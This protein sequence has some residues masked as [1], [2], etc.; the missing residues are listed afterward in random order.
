MRNR[1]FITLLFLTL[2]AGAVGVKAQI[3]DA[4]EAIERGNEYFNRGQYELAIFEYRGALNWPGGHQARARLN[5]GICR[6][7][8]GRPREAVAEYRAAIKL[9][10]GKYPSA[11]YALGFALKDWRDSEEAGEA[12]R[13]AGKVWGGN[14]A[15]ALLE[16]ALEPQRWGDDREPSEHSRQAI[17]QSRDGIPACHNNLGVILAK[18]GL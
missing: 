10:E 1:I 12:F 11:S 8:L 14:P 2:T 17:E 4:N 15:G 18:E 9:R 6:Q 13:K 7:R 5:I 16:R 3:N